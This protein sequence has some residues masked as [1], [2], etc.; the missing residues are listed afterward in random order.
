[1][2]RD[3]VAAWV[4][5]LRMERLRL[6]L[7]QSEV[8][9]RMGVNRTM[10]SLWENEVTQPLSGSLVSWAEALGFEITMSKVPESDE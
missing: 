2:R 5:V 7:K 9:E 8:A 3:V 1:M 4:E 6:K 10:L